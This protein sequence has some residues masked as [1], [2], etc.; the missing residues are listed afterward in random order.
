[1]FAKYKRQL[2]I[3]LHDANS[4]HVLHLHAKI[5]VTRYV[6]PR[7]DFWSANRPSK[8]KGE[9]YIYRTCKESSQKSQGKVTRV[10]H[11]FK[12]GFF[13]LIT[14]FSSRHPSL[15]FTVHCLSRRRSAMWISSSKDRATKKQ[16][17]FVIPT[18][19]VRL[20]RWKYLY[21]NEHGKHWTDEI[22][23]WDMHANKRIG[24]Y[25]SRESNLQ[26]FTYGW[27]FSTK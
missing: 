15:R 22:K 9:I 24:E 1:M 12:A 18:Q 21:I 20:T 2:K 25:K 23:V 27:Y 19:S 5:R 4:W 17:R 16:I 26:L 8:P 7:P 10:R 11:N 6:Y 14:W 3:N 13:T